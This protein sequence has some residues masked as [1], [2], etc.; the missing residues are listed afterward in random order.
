ME[1][2]TM[3]PVLSLV[4]MSLCVWGTLS[5]TNDCKQTVTITIVETLGQHLR[6]P[7]LYCNTNVC[8]GDVFLGENPF[9]SSPASSM[10]VGVMDGVCTVMNSLDRAV[11]RWTLYF[12]TTQSELQITGV[13]YPKPGNDS[14]VIVIAGTR[15]YA[16]VTGSGTTYLSPQQEYRYFDLFLCYPDNSLRQR[17][18]DGVLNYHEIPPIRDVLVPAI[19]GKW[20]LGSVDL[21]N[22]SFATDRNTFQIQGGYENGM[23]TFLGTRWTCQFNVVAPF[24]TNKI[25]MQG[26]I[27]SSPDTPAIIPIVGGTGVFGGVRGL[28]TVTAKQLQQNV[29]YWEVASTLKYGC[30][31]FS[32]T[33]RVSFRETVGSS[34]VIPSKRGN[35]ASPTEGDVRVFLD[36]LYFMD[37]RKE[38]EDSSTSK[39][40]YADGRVT[41]T[42]TLLANRNQHYCEWI[43]QYPMTGYANGRGASQIL[44]A[45]TVY[46]NPKTFS[47]IG[48]IGGT[49]LWTGATGWGTYQTLT[50]TP[51]DNQPGSNV[52]TFEIE[53]MYIAS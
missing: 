38:G 32:G 11:C 34:K 25:L 37:Q 27:A 47:T 22:N 31:L 26:S 36:D 42:C 29:Y 40:L 39:R 19:P 45:G 51:N 35:G 4:L 33:T 1:K 10:N 5:Q 18:S 52:A 8:A 16:G 14:E 53:F 15:D 13:S 9:N 12:P 23:C 24:E 30:I 7:S 3:R 44:L 2:S 20:S 21:F 41:G 49:G 17:C 50:A 48:V 6:V 43:V 46:D 28:A